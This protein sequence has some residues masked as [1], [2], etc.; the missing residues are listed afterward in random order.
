MAAAPPPPLLHPRLWFTLQFAG[1]TAVGV[2][3]LIPVADM[4]GNDKLLHFIAYGLMSGGFALLLRR[5]PTRLWAALGVVAY[6]VL[7]EY[8]QGLTGY[9]LFDP[10]DMLANGVGAVAGLVL[11]WRPLVEGFRRQERIL[12]K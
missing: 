6:G 3:S 2:L 11:G 12:W 1:V 10:A 9:R 8:L 4:G 7:L 5:W